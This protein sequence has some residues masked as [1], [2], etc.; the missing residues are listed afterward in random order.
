MGLLL[1]PMP[2]KTAYNIIRRYKRYADKAD[3]KV[4]HRARRSVRGGRNGE[5]DCTAQNKQQKRQHRGKPH[6][7]RYGVTR[8]K[9]R[10]AVVPTA[11]CLPDIDRS[12]HGKPHYHYR[13]V[14]GLEPVTPTK[15]N[16][17]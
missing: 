11:Y 17:A 7:Q 16:F 15:Q 6:K 9:R 14:T 10:P 3:G 12:A 1:S 5:N 2:R 13:S 4:I 8:K